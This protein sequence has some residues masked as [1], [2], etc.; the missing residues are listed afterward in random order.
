MV[1]VELSLEELFDQWQLQFPPSDDAQAVQASI[2]DM[3]RG[4][5]G[6]EFDEFTEEFRKRNGISQ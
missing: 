2:R 6:R 5:T 4:E 1:E 3:E